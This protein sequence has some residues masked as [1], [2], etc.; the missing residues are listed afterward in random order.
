[1]D[2]KM[3][4]MAKR[5]RIVDGMKVEKMKIKSDIDFKCLNETKENKT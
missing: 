1:M 2:L 5:A 3:S 4:Y